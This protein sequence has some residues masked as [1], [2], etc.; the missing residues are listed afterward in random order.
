MFGLFPDRA[1][2]QAGSFARTL[3]C[4]PCVLLVCLCTSVNTSDAGH[5][6]SP[7]IGSLAEV[8]T[9]SEA[10]VYWTGSRWLELE[11]FCARPGLRARFTN[12]EAFRLQGFD[13]ERVRIFHIWDTE[14]AGY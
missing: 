3:A 9:P 4:A 12:F 14:I 6:P 10:W 7:A 8:H 13:P 5:T 11:N 1:R 2:W